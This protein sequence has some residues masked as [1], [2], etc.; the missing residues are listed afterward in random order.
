MITK[1]A[2]IDDDEK[3]RNQVAAVIKTY[4]REK[5]FP[6]ELDLFENG[7]PLTAML[8]EQKRCD[9]YILDVE[10]DY[11][12][13]TELA[14]RIRQVDE[15]GII[16]FLTSYERYAVDGYSCK[17][18]DYI[19]K[20]RWQRRLPEV[21]ERVRVELTEREG[22]VYRIQSDRQYEVF[23]CSDIYY[24]TREGKQALFYCR[25]GRIYH[26]RRPMNEVFKRL[27]AGKFAFANRGQIVSL[28]YVT[29]LDA[30]RIELDG[31]INLEISRSQLGEL[32]QWLLE[33][34]RV[35]G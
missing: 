20:D 27:P 19:L 2:L 13:G 11:M 17:A 10:M 22:D 28:R 23:K 4:Y 18:F 32:R 7:R 15:E 5:A 30:E 3:L 9:V 33:Y 35:R 12:K 29:H 6:I 34:W 24:V 31:K 8:D 1:I 16:V 25:N 26:E 14:K 21:L